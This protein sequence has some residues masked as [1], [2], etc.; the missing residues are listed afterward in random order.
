MFTTG[1]YEIISLEIHCKTCTDPEHSFYSGLVT[2]LKKTL[3]FLLVRIPSNSLSTYIAQNDKLN[4]TFLKWKIILSRKSGISNSVEKHTGHGCALSTEKWFYTVSSPFF[5][6]HDY[7][8]IFQSN[9]I[10]L[11]HRKMHIYWFFIK[12]TDLASRIISCTHTTFEKEHYLL[13]FPVAL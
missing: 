10:C 4:S 8:N 11:L 1:V 7:W 9:D 12:A 3:W 13:S 6:G 5:N 2:L